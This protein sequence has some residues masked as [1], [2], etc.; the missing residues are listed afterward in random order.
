MVAISYP[1]FAQEATLKKLPSVAVL[2][3]NA[4]N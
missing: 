2:A 3:R 1:S 4:E